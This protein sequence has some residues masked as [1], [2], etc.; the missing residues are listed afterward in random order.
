MCNE[1]EGGGTEGS[2]TV[3]NIYTNFLSLPST[4]NFARQRITLVKIHVTELK[5]NGRLLNIK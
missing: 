2:E 1:E 5:P 4:K 3:A